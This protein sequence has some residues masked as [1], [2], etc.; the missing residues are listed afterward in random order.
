VGDLVPLGLWIE[1]ARGFYEKT[2]H[3]ND[4]LQ[5][6]KGRIVT[7]ATE[8]QEKVVLK[9]YEVHR[10]MIV[11]NRYLGSLELEISKKKRGEV[12]VVVVF[13][14]YDQ[15]RLIVRAKERAGEKK[16]RVVFDGS[17]FSQQRSEEVEEVRRLTEEFWEAAR[18]EKEQAITENR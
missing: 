10:P 18:K 6:M 3:R 4:V 11:H 2:V 7:T 16:A 14:I 13:E 8:D 12:E 17:T 1:I 9:I 5:S 15:Y